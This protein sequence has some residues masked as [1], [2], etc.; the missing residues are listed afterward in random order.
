MDTDYSF[1]PFYYQGRYKAFSPH[2][3]MYE[4]GVA[5]IP[6]KR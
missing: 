1:V 3:I 2:I 4:A 6:W 5:K